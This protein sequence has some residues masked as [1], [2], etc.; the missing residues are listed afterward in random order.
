MNKS[1]KTPNDPYI[2]IDDKLWPPYIEML[3]R[4]GI[5]LRH[6]TIVHRI[7]LTAFHH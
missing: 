3:L 7:R 2:D 6:P 1:L 4:S 5:I